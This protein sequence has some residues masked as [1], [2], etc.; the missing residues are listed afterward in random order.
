MKNNIVNRF[1]TNAF[2]IMVGRVFQIVLT[3]I[4][5]ML[6]TRYLGPTQYG[7]ITL[8]FSYVALFVPIATLGLNDILVKE[9]LNNKDDNENIIGTTIVLRL[10]SSLVSVVII[11]IVVKI[12]SSNP[13]LPII[14]LL[15]AILLLFRAFECITYFYQSKLLSKKVGIINVIAYSLTSIFRIVC[16]IIN[17]DIYWF[18]FAVALDY[19]VIAILLVLVYLK[20]GNKIRFSK[21]YI[22]LLLSKSRPYIFSG[23][24]TVVAGKIDT[25]MI[26]SFIDETSVGYYSAATQLCNA[27]PFVLTA[28]IDS[29]SPII[30]DSYNNDREDYNKKLKQLY[31]AIFYI[32]LFVAIIFTVFS[33]QIITIV[34]GNSFL[35]ASKALRFVCWNTIFSYFGVARFIWMQSENKYNYERIITFFGAVFNVV[36]NYLLINRYGII[37]ASITLV[38]TQFFMNFLILFFIKETRPNAKLMLDAIILKNIK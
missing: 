15:Q 6:V 24:M 27:W 20:D 25:I 4:T 11:F 10:L 33:K 35:E 29:A 30:I 16:L 21:K 18:A 13:I 28:I 23:I 36:L 19:I 3:F 14:A 12:V 22:S 2:W 5:T 26:G 34:Y 32:G 31:A 37:G 9:L 8:A 17:K 38:L 1:T 7:Q